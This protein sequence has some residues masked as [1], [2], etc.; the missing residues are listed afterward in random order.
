MCDDVEDARDVV[1][2]G[3]EVFHQISDQGS[4][5]A[6]IQLPSGSDLSRYQPRHPTAYD[7]DS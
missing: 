1:A 4:A 5:A 6:S 2:K 7:L 3:V